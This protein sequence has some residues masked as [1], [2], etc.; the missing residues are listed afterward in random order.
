MVDGSG[1]PESIQTDA[2]CAWMERM[3]LHSQLGMVLL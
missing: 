3:Q 2:S 1:V